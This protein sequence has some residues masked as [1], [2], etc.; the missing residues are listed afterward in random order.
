MEEALL[1]W[2]IAV[3]WGQLSPR[4]DRFVRTIFT[5][6]VS[7]FLTG[8]RPLDARVLPSIL[9]SMSWNLCKDLVA[10]LLKVENAVRGFVHVPGAHDGSDVR[11]FDK[12]FYAQLGAESRAPVI[13][14]GI[15]R[16]VWKKTRARNE[17]LDC[18]VMG[19]VALE[20]LH[21]NLDDIALL[22]VDDRI[23]IAE[24]VSQSH[25][26]H[27]TGRNPR[28][29]GGTSPDAENSTMRIVL[30]TS[31]SNS[32]SALPGSWKYSW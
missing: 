18:L 15:K 22:T 5:S 29:S 27:V 4:S 20:S 32:A 14:G 26:L 1:R 21:M 11:G 17:A 30:R 8:S 13:R 10:G 12:G 7:R 23:A 9:M 31:A 6:P 28:L 24:G 3:N 19:P 2:C 16:F 25:R